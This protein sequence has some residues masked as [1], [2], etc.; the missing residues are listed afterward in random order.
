MITASFIKNG[1]CYIVMDNGEIWCVYQSGQGEYA[2][3][4]IATLPLIS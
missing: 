1:R 4:K 2:V 3:E